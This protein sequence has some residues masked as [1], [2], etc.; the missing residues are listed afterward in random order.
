M[1]HEKRGVITTELP[2]LLDRVLGLKG[3]IEDGF[4]TVHGP[5]LNEPYDESFCRGLAEKISAEAV[6][7]L[8]NRHGNM[9]WSNVFL[10]SGVVVLCEGTVYARLKGIAEEAIAF[11][12]KVSGKECSIFLSV[13]IRSAAINTG[14]VAYD[15]KMHVTRIQSQSL[16]RIRE[17]DPSERFDFLD[18]LLRHE[19]YGGPDYDKLRIKN[20]KPE[21]ERLLDRYRVIPALTR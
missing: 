1:I 21:F 17:C 18:L 10:G 3:Y 14:S 11:L 15:S 19:V 20:I 16:D 9:A 4:E 8:G 12:K 2:E 13:S 6:L 5:F 7:G